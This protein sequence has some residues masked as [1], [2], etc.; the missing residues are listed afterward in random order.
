[1]FP[2]TPVPFIPVGRNAFH[3]NPP[4][5]CIPATSLISLQE[6][7]VCLLCVNRRNED[8]DSHIHSLSLKAFVALYSAERI[9]LKT[10][11]A[12]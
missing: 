1:M 2:F 11:V 3:H 6:C 7:T 5:E 10:E 9:F 12:V 8:N 4:P